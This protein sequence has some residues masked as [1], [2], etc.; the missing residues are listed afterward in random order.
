MESDGSSSGIGLSLSNGDFK[1][2]GTDTRLLVR[3]RF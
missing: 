2:N 1:S 3:F